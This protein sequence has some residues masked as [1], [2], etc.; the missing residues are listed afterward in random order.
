MTLNINGVEVLEKKEYWGRQYSF[1]DKDNEFMLNIVEMT[2]G[3]FYE[4]SKEIDDFEEYD[5][6]EKFDVMTIAGYDWE[7]KEGKEQPCIWKAFKV[8]EK[9]G[10]RH[11]R[12][13]RPEILYYRF[14]DE[15]A[16]KAYQPWIEIKDYKLVHKKD[17]LAVYYREKNSEIQ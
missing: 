14:E 8:F 10:Q 16:H 1:L 13:Y 17:G 4:L 15:R 3:E 6:I 11:S 9:V 2:I 7:V 12:L 5:V